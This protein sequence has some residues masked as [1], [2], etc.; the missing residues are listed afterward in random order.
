MLSEF[1]RKWFLQTR[2][3]LPS[4]ANCPRFLH[5][6]LMPLLLYLLH[7]TCIFS[8]LYFNSLWH[9]HSRPSLFSSSSLSSPP[10]P[11]KNYPPPRLR[12]R[13]LKQEPQTPCL[14]PP[15]WSVPRS[16]CLS[17]RSSSSR[18]SYFAFHE[19]INIPK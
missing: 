8:L 10:P 15:P 6:K 19:W 17:W 13:R 7:W 18:I 16:F 11:L 9:Q 2:T 5:Y 14:A 1:S 4:S 3:R 12:H